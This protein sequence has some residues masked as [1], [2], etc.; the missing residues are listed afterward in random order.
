MDARFPGTDE[1]FG[2]KTAAVRLSLASRLKAIFT[3]DHPFIVR[4][5]RII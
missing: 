3:A 5:R 1:E 4:N 2:E